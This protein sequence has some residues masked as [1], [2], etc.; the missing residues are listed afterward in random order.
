MIMQFQVLN[1]CTMVLSLLPLVLMQ[2]CQSIIIVIPHDTSHAVG[3][4]MCS[5]VSKTLDAK[6]LV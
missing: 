1:F 2:I 3:D 4:P 6:L 5:R